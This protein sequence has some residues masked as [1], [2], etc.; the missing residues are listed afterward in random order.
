VTTGARIAALGQALRWTAGEFSADL[1]ERHYLA[2]L[3][4]ARLLSADPR[5]EGVALSGP[6][7]HAQLRTALCTVALEIRAMAGET[8][9]A[10]RAL[11]AP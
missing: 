5:L 11:L 10:R 6:E 3:A 2:H 9:A 1:N 8:A 4:L 7:A